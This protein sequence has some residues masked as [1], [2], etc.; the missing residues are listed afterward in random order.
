MNSFQKAIE[1]LAKMPSIG[2]KTAQ[3]IAFYLLKS[4]DKTVD[5]LVEALK[6]LKEKVH[7][8][9]ICFG[10][11]EEDP[12]PICTSPKRNPSL[13]CIVSEASDLLAL[14]R[15]KGYKGHYHVLGGT[16]SPLDGIG[17]DD[18]HIKELLNRLENNEQIKEIIIAT[19]PN[20][21]GEA[22]ALYIS[23]LLKPLGLKITRIARGLQAGSDLDYVDQVSLL[24][25]LD[26]RREL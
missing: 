4:Q 5:D 16:L 10:V 11:T 3:R 17:P 14:E 20:V 19:N 26:E 9:S 23:K 12:C 6:A 8:C 24:R 15:T 1:E 2:K 21:E 13:L 18:L 22:T 25:A 7:Y